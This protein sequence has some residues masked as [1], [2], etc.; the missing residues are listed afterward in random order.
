MGIVRC[1]LMWIQ[2]LMP[3]QKSGPKEK[4]DEDKEAAERHYTC[5]FATRSVIKEYET[6][7]NMRTRDLFPC[8]RVLFSVSYSFVNM[9]ADLN[10]DAL[11]QK[12][13]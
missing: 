6:E 4:S 9:Y 3:C 7:Q 5:P 12:S 2:L 13:L 11:F 1:R 10:S 8:S